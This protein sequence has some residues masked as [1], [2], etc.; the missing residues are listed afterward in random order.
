M[1]EILNTLRMAVG[2]PVTHAGT[3]RQLARVARQHQRHVGV[4]P[5]TL[6]KTLTKIGQ[7]MVKYRSADGST[8]GTI[9]LMICSLCED[10]GVLGESHLDAQDRIRVALDWYVDAFTPP[11]GQDDRRKG[12]RR[13]LSAYGCDK[14]TI[15]NAVKPRKNG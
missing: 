15:D 6:A 2:D 3:I 1:V 5:Q 4:P 7:Y 12:L 10:I 8:Q 14:R 13:V 11:V 9:A